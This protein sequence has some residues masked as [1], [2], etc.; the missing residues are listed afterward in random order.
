MTTTPVCNA[1]RSFTCVSYSQ[2]EGTWKIEAAN[3][4][5]QHG[6]CLAAARSFQQVWLRPGTQ[7]IQLR[8]LAILAPLLVLITLLVPH[9]ASSV[10]ARYVTATFL[11]N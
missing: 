2:L 9:P 11:E 4:T 7:P 8:P 6:E 5:A 10:V 3:L 1:L